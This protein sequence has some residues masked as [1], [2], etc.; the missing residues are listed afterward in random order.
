MNPEIPQWLLKQEKLTAREWKQRKRREVQAALTA[1][2][3]LFLGCAHTPTVTGVS[4]GEVLVNLQRI[5]RAWSQ[6]E[7]GK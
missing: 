1:V 3:V 5:Q 7:W 6:K 4:V 2:R